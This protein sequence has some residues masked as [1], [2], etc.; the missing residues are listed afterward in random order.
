MH[1][2]AVVINKYLEKK[3]RNN[4]EIYQIPSS[5]ISGTVNLLRV[6]P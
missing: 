6:L 5:S 3:Q 2:F 4:T 1:T